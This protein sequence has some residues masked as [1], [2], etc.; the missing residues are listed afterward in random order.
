MFTRRIIVG[1]HVIGSLWA[2]VT[3]RGPIIVAFLSARMHNLTMSPV[4]KTVA[5]FAVTHLK[6]Y[7]FTISV[8]CTASFR[9]FNH[10]T[11][12]IL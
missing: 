2:V 12:A 4:M 7:C 3:N 11:A 1:F 9:R 10:L 6:Q 8:G 5:V